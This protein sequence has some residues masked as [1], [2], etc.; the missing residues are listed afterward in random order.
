[1]DSSH[2]L[3]AP[4]NDSLSRIDQ[5]GDHSDL[6]TLYRKAK[7]DWTGELVSD[8]ERDRRRQEKFD[9]ISFGIRKEFATISLLITAP[10][11]ISSII[12]TVAFTFVDE[13]NRPI[14]GIPTIFLFLFW[15]IGTFF[16]YKKVYAL[17]YNNALQATPFICVLLTYL[18]LFATILHILTAG[19]HNQ[20][21]LY[22]TIIVSGLE[23]LLGIAI[24]LPLLLLWTTPKLSGN[25]KLAI[26]VAPIIAL[27]GVNIYLIVT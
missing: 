13:K 27:I 22:S 12:A 17:F 2:K 9:T 6:S 7:N 21:P 25:L 19:I 14:L 3:D 8:S 20:N 4:D 18:G 5:V 16:A 1:M 15:V 26:I 23:L 10:L 24:S 11:I